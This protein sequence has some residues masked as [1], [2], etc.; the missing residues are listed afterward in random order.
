MNSKCGNYFATDFMQI[1]RKEDNVLL[2]FLTIK[3]N[4]IFL[5]LYDFS[6]IILLV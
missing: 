4:I 5:Q 6:G 3:Y 2:F 1:N